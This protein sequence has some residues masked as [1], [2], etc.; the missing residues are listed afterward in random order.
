MTFTGI[1]ERGVVEIGRYQTAAGAALEGVRIGY[2]ILGD[3]DSGRPVILI[4]SLHN[5]TSHFAGYYRDPRTGLADQDKGP[6]L[7]SKLTGPGRA[8]DTERY[9]LI[10]VDGFCAFDLH[11]PYITTTGPSTVDPG[12]GRPYGLSFPPLMLRD[13]V[14][15][16][17]TVLDRL[18]I[19]VLH[20]VVGG[21]MGGLQAFEWAALYPE[22]VGCFAAAVSG[23]R[24]NAWSML[25]YREARLAVMGDPDWRDGAYYG[26]PGPLSGLRTAFRHFTQD[27]L[28]P[29]YINSMKAARA[30]LPH[31]ARPWAD[32]ARD[33]FVDS[34]HE[35][36]AAA[37]LEDKAAAR[38][39]LADANHFI[40]IQRALELFSLGAEV[41]ADG[42][43][44]ERPLDEALGSI[45][46]PALLLP[47]PDDEIVPLSEVELARDLLAAQGNTVEL[48]PLTGGLG[49]ITGIFGLDE[50]NDV[51]AAFLERHGQGPGGRS[52]QTGDGAI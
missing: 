11:D 12:T 32:P 8:L 10:G 3:P 29:R 41:L 50:A 13:Q 19:T 28:S 52:G 6:G 37:W 15:I 30:P 44:R 49:H 48:H 34:A 14:R 42:R 46:A 43:V 45:R 27:I 47:A 25:K 38:A 5:G 26:T 18:G 35:F 1:A 39:A 24:S 40:Y 16:Q 51:I 20:A 9:V 7:W 23:P 4:P 17:R 33:P 31:G 21:S 22:M 2:T 36:A